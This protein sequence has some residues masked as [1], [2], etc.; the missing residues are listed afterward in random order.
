MCFF[1]PKRKDNGIKQSNEYQ[2]QT[3]ATGNETTNP[4]TYNT[5]IAKAIWKTQSFK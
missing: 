4:C 3:Q 2:V 1:F 5:L